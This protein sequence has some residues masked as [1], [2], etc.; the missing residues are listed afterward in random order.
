VPLLSLPSPP[1]P[2]MATSVTYYF[3]YHHSPPSCQYC[4]HTITV[5]SSTAATMIAVATTPPL[6]SAPLLLWPLLSPSLPVH[7]RHH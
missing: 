5:T 7:H 6:P 4:C 1:L 3:Q 2:I